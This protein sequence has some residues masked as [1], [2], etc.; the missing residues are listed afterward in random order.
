MAKKKQKKKKKDCRGKE[1]ESHKKEILNTVIVA[2]LTVI[3]TKGCDLLIPSRIKFK[4]VP[5][6]HMVVEHSFDFGEVQ[7]DS[8][9]ESRIENII[10]LEEIEQKLDLRRNG[11]QT[12]RVLFN[13]VCPNAKGY[14]LGNSAPYCTVGLIQSTEGGYIDS[15]LVFFDNGI[16]DRISFVGIKVYRENN[17]GSS[18]FVMDVN[19]FPKADNTMRVANTLVKGKYK[20]EIGFTFKRDADKK[21]P[22][23]YRQSKL[24]TV[25]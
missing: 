22:T 6:E 12:N 9:L 10:K 18:V 20:F 23:F 14:T 2:F 7:E 5:I 3:L 11:F 15:K 19:Y 25:I 13:N 24:M 16:V 1:K 21:Y 17:D 4:D 8:L